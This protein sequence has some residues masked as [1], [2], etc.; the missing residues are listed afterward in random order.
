MTAM[1]SKLFSGTRNSW[2]M[3]KRSIK[4]DLR[5]VD[6][7]A[8][9]VILPV[10]ILVLF[11]TIFGGAIYTGVDYINYVVPGVFLICL[12][13]GTAGTAVSVCDDNMK[14][15]IDRFRSMPI[16]SVSV[17][18]GHVAASIVRNTFAMIV[19]SLLAIALGFRPSATFIEWLGVFGI[20][21]LLMLALTWAAA[22]F[23]L[24]VKNVEAAGSFMFTTMLLPY[25]SSSFVLISTLPVWLQGFAREQPINHAVE[26]I[27]ALLL[28]GSVGDHA[29]ITAIWCLA[30]TAIM[31]GIARVLFQRQAA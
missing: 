15:I 19:V 5:S 8:M 11:T 29:W 13:F 31:Y 17:L 2:T 30:V 25:L 6:A 12:G 10:M 27:R 24:F 14:G 4:H 9:S 23:G 1:K 28:N 22:A 3:I 21:W 18:T 20:L 16:N 26:A 7:L